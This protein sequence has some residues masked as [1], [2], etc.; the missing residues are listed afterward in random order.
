MKMDRGAT[1][2]QRTA[3]QC[4]AAERQQSRA[5]A[6][7]RGGQ[8]LRRAAPRGDGGSDTMSRMEEGK[9]RLNCIVLERGPLGY[10]YM[11]H[12]PNPRIEE[13]TILPLTIIL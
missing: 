8:R 11:R 4:R 1:A 13:K 7:N 5:E 6:T 12:T 3:P 10:I 2:E 9:E